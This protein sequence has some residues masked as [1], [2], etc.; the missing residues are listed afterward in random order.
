MVKQNFY[1]NKEVTAHLNLLN[2]KGP[3]R[4][5]YGEITKDAA[6]QTRK[7]KPVSRINPNRKW[8]CNTKMITQNE[9]DNFRN[10]VET[11]SVYQVLL[12]KGKVPY[13]LLSEEK[14]KRGKVE[15]RSVFGKR[16]TRKRP[17]IGSVNVGDIVNEARIK[18]VKY[19]EKILALDENVVDNNL[20]NKNF[21]VNMTE[22]NIVK[23]SE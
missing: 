4:N 9:L 21:S 8:F 11:K 10:T 2:T 18:Q 15:Y 12:S 19:E 16:A 14:G 7:C 22:N 6:F 23:N 1:H 3:T 20:H 5:A 17:K 13:S